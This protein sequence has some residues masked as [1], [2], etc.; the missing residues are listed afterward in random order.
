ME[1]EKGEDAEPEPEPK[2]ATGVDTAL[3]VDPNKEAG[4]DGPKVELSGSSV[5]GSVAIV[6][7]SL[8]RFSALGLSNMGD[9]LASRGLS[10]AVALTGCASLMP[11]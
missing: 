7:I 10:V 2:A 4:A 5:I 9:R 1:N 3:D 8:C 6:S 11:A